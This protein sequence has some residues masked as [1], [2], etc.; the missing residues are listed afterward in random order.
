MHGRHYTGGMWGRRRDT[1]PQAAHAQE[2]RQLQE[3]LALIDSLV[4]RTVQLG[5]FRP[6]VDAVD[7]G[8]GPLDTQRAVAAKLGRV[9]AVL[10]REHARFDEFADLEVTAL[11]RTGRSREAVDRRAQ[12]LGH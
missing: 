5:D 3:I 7:R 10:P 1:E 12:V 11:E 8:L 4:A 9:L 6:L 2:E